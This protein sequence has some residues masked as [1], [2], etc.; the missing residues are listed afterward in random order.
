MKQFFYLIAAIAIVAVVVGF[1]TRDGDDQTANV[2]DTQEE[3]EATEEVMQEGATI[4][5]FDEDGNPV[6]L[7][8]EIVAPGD[9][10]VEAE[11]EA[12]ASMEEEK[13]MERD[14][15]GQTAQ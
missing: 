5:A 11:A 4:Q 2:A 8:I 1:G 10:S 7:N 12:E 14:T 3:M 13:M 6:E 9:G 15:S